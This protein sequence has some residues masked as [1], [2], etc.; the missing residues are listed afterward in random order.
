MPANS[1]WDFNSGFK[2]LMPCLPGVLLRYFMSDFEMVLFTP[3]LA[4]VTLII[5]FLCISK[6]FRLL[7]PSNFYLL[8]LQFLLISMFLFS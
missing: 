3:V 2:G 1:R 8:I 4:G 6:S 7:Y 5:Y